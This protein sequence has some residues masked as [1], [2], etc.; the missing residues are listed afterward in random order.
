MIAATI[1]NPGAL[2]GG[3]SPLPPPVASFA[4]SDTDSFVGGIVSFTDTSTGGPT[5]WS[6]TSNGAEFSTMQN[7]NLY[8][9]APG[10]YVIVLTATNAFGSS[11]SS[12]LNINVSNLAP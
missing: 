11:T 1:I 5:S 9:G 10:V 8:F 4:A 2:S 7:P 3:G 6:W 12:P